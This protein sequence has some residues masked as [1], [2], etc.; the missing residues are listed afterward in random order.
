MGSYDG[1]NGDFLMLYTLIPFVMEIKVLLDWTF[2]KTSLD[3]FQW[4]RFT[5]IH[6]DIYM[7]RCGNYAYAK[8]R[9]GEEIDLCE[10]ALCGVFFLVLIL[11]LLVMPLF[12]FS[13]LGTSLN[14]IISADLA[15]NL[16]ISNKDGMSSELNL[17]QTNLVEQ[18][19]TFHDSDFN[20][21]TTFANDDK[22]K[23]YVPEQIQEIRMSNYSQEMWGAT[24]PLKQVFI[25]ALQKGSHDTVYLEFKT[26]F[27]RE[28]SLNL[29]STLVTTLHLQTREEKDKMLNLLERKC[30]N[31]DNKEKKSFVLAPDLIYSVSFYFELTYFRLCSSMEPVSL[32]SSRS[33][34]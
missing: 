12:L 24:P 6:Y 29:Q 28:G 33:S 27:M 17:F 16:K 1:M 8:R 11:L 18:I 20:Y 25:D 13:D 21:Q 19:R 31:Q 23:N 22:T 4:F 34:L 32:S 14:P 5:N 15:F 7:Y 30:D 3:I 2:S 26:N 10:K 9:Q